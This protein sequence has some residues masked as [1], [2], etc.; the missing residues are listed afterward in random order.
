MALASKC[1]RCGKY[2]KWI[3]EETHGFAYVTYSRD[4]HYSIEGGA[5]DLCPDCIKSLEDWNKKGEIE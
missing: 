4:G 3:M 2:Y 5:Y 1:D